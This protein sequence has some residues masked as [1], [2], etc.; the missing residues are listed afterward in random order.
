LI[1]PIAAAARR[2]DSVASSRETDRVVAEATTGFAL[3]IA[4]TD[5]LA[6]DFDLAPHAQPTG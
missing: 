6:G 5:E 1:Q 4:L 2:A 3:N